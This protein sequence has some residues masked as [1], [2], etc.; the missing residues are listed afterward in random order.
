MDYR[1]QV[2]T[3][4]ILDQDLCH[5]MALLGHSELNFIAMD[6]RRQVIT[7]AI[8]DQDLCHHMALLGHS[9]LNFIAMDY[10]KTVVCPMLKHR[11]YPSRA[12]SHQY[13]L[14][15]LNPCNFRDKCRRLSGVENAG[16]PVGCTEA[17]L[18][19]FALIAVS[20][21]VKVPVKSFQPHSYL[22]G[23]TAA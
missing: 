15:W 9:E 7:Q 3:Q 10:L 14:F 6:Y 8:L 12:Q 19:R 2:I 1:R 21:L 11:R 16:L 23:V 4:A 22:T 18:I 17:P 13:P 5:H 20:D